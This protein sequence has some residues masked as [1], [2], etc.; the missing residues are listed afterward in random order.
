[1]LLYYYGMETCK[2]IRSILSRVLSTALEIIL[3]KFRKYFYFGTM[4]LL[5]EGITYDKKLQKNTVNTRRLC[6]DSNNRTF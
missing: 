3:V 6:P 4:T 1:M 2:T 5:T